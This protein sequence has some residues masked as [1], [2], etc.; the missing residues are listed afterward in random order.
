[1]VTDSSEAWVIRKFYAGDTSARVVFFTQNQGLITGHCK[2]GRTPQKQALL[3]AFTPLWLSF[4]T[5]GTAHFVNR[6]EL[7]SATLPLQGGSLLAG[8]YVNE[9]LYH[10]L[11]PLDAHASLHAAY[12]CVLQALTIAQDRFAVEAALRRFEWSLLSACGYAMSLTQD[13]RTATPIGA[14][15]YYQF[16]AGEGFVLAKEG[17]YGAHILAMADD[18][19]DDRAVL[20]TAKRIMRLAIQQVIHGKEIRTRALFR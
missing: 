6:I 15:Q 11:K 18:Q 12:G 10:A 3:Q 8:L 19:L 5:R 16:I 13:A 14:S 7:A 4:T 1:M 17:Y 20:T 2:G 9:L